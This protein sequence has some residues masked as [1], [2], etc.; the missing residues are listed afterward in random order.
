ME[1]I[2]HHVHTQRGLLWES[3]EDL[4]KAIRGV[5]GCVEHHTEAMQAACPVTHKLENGL[6]TREVFMPAGDLVISF[7]HKQNHPSFFMEGDMSLLLDDGTVK[8]IKAPMVVHTE[9][10]TQRVAYIH[11]DTKWVCVYRT[12]AETVEEAEKEVY[13]MDF[14]ELP[15]SVIQKKLCQV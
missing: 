13:T 15:E 6:Y 3:I 7:I 5:E 10:G 8:R 9:V 14:R 11:E 1:E 12:D 2:L 4:Y